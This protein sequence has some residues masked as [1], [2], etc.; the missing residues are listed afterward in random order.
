M[1]RN[2]LMTS[3]TEK[4]PPSGYIVPGAHFRVNTNEGSTVGLGRPAEDFQFNNSDPILNPSTTGVN[5][6]MYPTGARFWHNGFTQNETA[7][8]GTATVVDE[9]VGD[10]HAVLFS[11]N[12]LFRAYEESGEHMFAN[13]VL[14]P[15]SSTGSAGVTNLR[16]AAGRSEARA[17]DSSFVEA[18]LGGD[19]RPIQIAVARADAAE[20]ADIVGEFTSAA[21][22]TS[23]GSSTYIE[24]ANRRGLA[25]DEH[26]FARD[27]LEALHDAGVQ[28]RAAVL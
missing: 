28:I 18:N 8:E 2:A 27:L 22:I 4:A 25:A 9:P 20:T 13:A 7:L 11:Y 12:A 14:H 6:Q 15:S 24:I 17:A 26:P 21:S 10:G 16:S 1:A 19:W 23:S 5:V 3:T